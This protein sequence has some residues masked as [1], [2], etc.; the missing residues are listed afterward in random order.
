MMGGTQKVLLGLLFGGGHSGSAASGL[1]SCLGHHQSHKSTLR[2]CASPVF[3]DGA[4]FVARNL[5]RGAE[6]V[7]EFY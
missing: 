3:L 1:W 4:I 6:H 2:P 5:E 7:L